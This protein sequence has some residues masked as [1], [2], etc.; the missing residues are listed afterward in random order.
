[1]SLYL[2][3]KALGPCVTEKDEGD[4]ERDGEPGSPIWPAKY[5]ALWF[6]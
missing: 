6:Q 2:A 1:M 4:P 3:D 5:W